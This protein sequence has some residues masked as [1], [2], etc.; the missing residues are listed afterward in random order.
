M[1]VR[2]AMH[3]G[4]IP[5]GVPYVGNPSSR[6][7]KYTCVKC[8]EANVGSI[9]KVRRLS[10]AEQNGILS[11]IAGGMAK[12]VKGAATLTARGIKAAAPHVKRGVVAAGRLAVKGGK[13][14]IKHGVPLAKK[15][16]GATVRGAKAIGRETGKAVEAHR[17]LKLM[18]AQTELARAQQGRVVATVNPSRRRRGNPRTAHQKIKRRVWLNCR[19]SS[20]SWS[21]RKDGR[22]FCGECHRILPRSS[23]RNVESNK[24]RSTRLQRNPTYGLFSPD[25]MEGIPVEVDKYGA[26]GHH[27]PFSLSRISEQNPR[28]NRLHPD[29]PSAGRCP[30]CKSTNTAGPSYPGDY[31]DCLDCGH[32]WPA[33]IRPTQRSHRK[34]IFQKT[35]PQCPC[36]ACIGATPLKWRPMGTSEQNPRYRRL[37]RPLTDVDVAERERIEWERGMDELEES[38]PRRLRRKKDLQHTPIWNWLLENQIPSKTVRKELSEMT[39]R[40]LPPGTRWEENPRGRECGNCGY[41]RV[42]GDA[43]PG[44]SGRNRCP[45]CWAF[46]LSRCPGCKA[47]LGSSN[48]DIQAC[49]KSRREENQ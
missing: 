33:R 22:L 46:Y 29:L 48:H 30:R 40:K 25:D 44:I 27:G 43:G 10:R 1:S 9:R 19:H 38:N 13:A 35:K 15:A 26:E 32:S 20:Q 14:A 23:L 11:S 42:V 16:A 12:G 21:M 28:Y 6:G 34:E 3:N 2:C 49:Q 24:W 47:I 36:P 37:R 39:G 41:R 45:R 18:K 8:Y 7:M 17:E 5:K 31:N 4:P